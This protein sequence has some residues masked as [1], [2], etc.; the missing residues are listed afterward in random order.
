VKL[1]I[2]LFLVIS[3]YSTVTLAQTPLVAVA[4][5]M[6]HVMTD[7]ADKYRSIT[8]KNV[9]LTFGSSGNFTRQ[10]RQG[11]PYNIFLSAAG[12]YVNILAKYGILQQA[13][14]AYARGQIGLF[15]PRDSRL[16]T[17]GDLTS[18]FNALDYGDYQRIAI[19]N[20]EHAPYGVAAVQSLQSGGLWAVEKE[21]LLIAENAAQVVQY[22]LSGGVDLGI[23]P[24]SFA[25]LP[26]I[27]EHGRFL[28]IPPDWHQPIQQY[29]AL[30]RDA[31]KDSQDFYQF[32]LGDEVRA[33]LTKSGYVVTDQN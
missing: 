9:K 32:L 10:I 27:M 13:P 25:K 21:R 4:S 26:V 20:P 22:T 12:K 19:A 31:G 17:A 8:G 16:Y 23:I 7:I 24:A 15:I 29:L 28:P 11:A 14:V 18:V 5:N 6:T 2:I 3:I 30:I 33:L 1:R